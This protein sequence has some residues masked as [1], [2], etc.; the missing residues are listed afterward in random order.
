[1]ILGPWKPTDVLSAEVIQTIFDNNLVSPSIELFPEFTEGMKSMSGLCG[2]PGNILKTLRKLLKRE[3]S[4]PSPQIVGGN[5]A[6]AHTYPWMA[7][8]FVDGKYFCGGTLISDEW[9]LTAAHCVDGNALEVKV[10]LGAHNI[11]A[12]EEDGRLSVNTMM[13]FTHPAYNPSLLQNDIALIHLINPVQ[14][15]NKIR[16]VCLPSN[17]DTEIA[18]E[19]QKVGW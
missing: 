3:F 15:T 13:F 5:E 1:M 9:V 18:F 4:G 10:M 19:G 14:F 7:A 16:P 2:L 8:L 12:E 11:K 17:A 6:M